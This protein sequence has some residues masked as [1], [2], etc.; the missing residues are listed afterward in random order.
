M[1]KDY[2]LELMRV[3]SMF[4]VIVIHMSN[5]YCRNI[6]M[7]SSFS[8][9][10]A[11]IFNGIARLAVPLFFMI[12]GALLINKT[13]DDQTTKKRVIK[14][15]TVLLI[16]TVIYLIWNFFYLGVSTNIL[17]AIFDPIKGH[18][19]YMYAIIGLYIALPFI[20]KMIINLNEKEEDLFIKLW[21][22]LTGGVYIFRLILSFFG[23]HTVIIY[24]VPIFQATYYLGYFVAGY[25]IYNR[26]KDK[27]AT[28]N[29]ILFWLA[30]ISL[31]IT[32]VGTYV[33]SS[34]GNVYYESL[35]AYRSLFYIVASLAVFNLII[36]N[37]KKLLTKNTIKVIDAI[38]PYSF[39]VYLVHVIFLNMLMQTS[40]MTSVTSI[41]GIPVFSL[42][43]FA[44]SYAVIYLLKKV[45]YI[46]DYI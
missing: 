40:D 29:K 37:S 3:S 30:G 46:K 4:L 26:V 43:L 20:R 36:S 18:L 14:M 17:N 27:P 39:G 15:A 13:E 5:Y 41:I 34:M 38:A 42:L 6:D 33:I 25:I 2:S 11:T 19:W 1:K 44:V 45:K 7:I 35:F 22:L 21:I 32:I 8:Y 10:G 24:P 28:N 23:V 16:W 9:F 12:S 31:L